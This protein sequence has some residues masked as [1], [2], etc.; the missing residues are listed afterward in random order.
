[1]F[2]T[3]RIVRSTSTTCI[4]PLC[5]RYI[6]IQKQKTTANVKKK[7]NVQVSTA[8][9]KKSKKP[10]ATQTNRPR[11]QLRNVYANINHNVSPVVECLT[12]EVGHEI[13]SRFCISVLKN[14][15]FNLQLSE[16]NKKHHVLTGD[17][18]LPGHQ[19]NV[20]GS[21]TL[22]KDDLK[23][24]STNIERSTK[25]APENS[26]CLFINNVG[27]RGEAVRTFVKSEKPCILMSVSDSS[28]NWLG[29]PS[30][31]LKHRE[32]IEKCLHHQL[33]DNDI[34]FSS[35]KFSTSRATV[36]RYSLTQGISLL[37][38][39]RAFISFAPKLTAGKFIYQWPKGTKKKRLLKTYFYSTV[40]IDSNKG[41]QD[42]FDV[43]QQ[44]K[45]QELELY[46][47]AQMRNYNESKG[48]DVS[49][50]DILGVSN[51][52]VIKDGDFDQREDEMVNIFSF[53]TDRDSYYGDEY[54]AASDDNWRVH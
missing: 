20:V 28:N 46:Y 48:V 14:Y 19:M 47:Q 17:W 45:R 7:K 54:F 30:S 33:W 5:V 27:F 44:E 18:T 29:Q 39:N 4:S 36:P 31:F 12:P 50:G 2:S 25:E 40:L 38:F 51:S 24:C 23:N 16:N 52:D 53:L 42:L 3:H 32:H 6:G 13:Y 8:S 11:F 34:G 49:I 21:C 43:L 9:K 22:Q 1:M 10:A 26:V 35:Y 37:L 15:G 41:K